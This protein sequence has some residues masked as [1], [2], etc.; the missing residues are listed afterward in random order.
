EPILS[1]RDIIPQEVLKSRKKQIKARLV[2]GIT[3]LI[4]WLMP[5][6]KR[7]VERKRDYMINW[8]LDK[9][10]SDHLL[11]ISKSAGVTVNTLLCKTIL[12]AFRETGSADFQNKIV[13]PVDIKKYIPLIKEENIFPFVSMVILSAD[14]GLDFINDALRMQEYVAKKMENLDPYAM[15]M[16]MEASH[17]SLEDLSNFLK[18]S[19]LGSDCLLSNLG[20]IGIKHDYRSF[21][22][23]T[24]YSP[25]AVGPLGKTTGLVTSTYRGQVD[26]TFISSEGFLPHYEALKIKDKIIEIIRT[27]PVSANGL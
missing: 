4:L 1:L 22:V 3:A 12:T 17:G 27:M 18:Y 23:E 6:K 9:E 26:F 24:I 21:E 2:G 19:K 7:A 16:Q 5:L 25:S 15:I 20:K 14:T 8:K 10:I 11:G 13:C